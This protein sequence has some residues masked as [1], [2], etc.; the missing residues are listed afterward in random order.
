MKEGTKGFFVI[1]IYHMIPVR[2]HMS[3]PRHPSK[4]AR[5]RFFDIPHIRA[6]GI[7]PIIKPP[8]CPRITE[9]PPWKEEKTGAPI[10][11]SKTYTKAAHP[12]FFMPKKYPHRHIA[13]V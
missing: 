3:M 9:N 8:P 4:M 11:P 2:W 5:E 6:R 13:K 1:T 10:A 12:P 7:N